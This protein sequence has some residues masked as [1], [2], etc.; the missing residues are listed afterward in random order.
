MGSP[1]ASVLAN[2]FM[3]F[4]QSKWLN[5]YNLNKP[6]FYLRYV[7]DILAA[8]EKRQNS[9]HFLNSVTNKHPNNKFTIEKQ[10]NRSIA[11]LDVFIS[12]IDHWPI[13]FL[14]SA[15]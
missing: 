7:N 14:G 9:L 13:Q 11:F 5:E 3:G 12:G 8:F 1:L 10:A 6:D 15:R 2:V 4:Y